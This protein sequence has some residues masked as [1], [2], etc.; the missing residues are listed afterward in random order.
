[1]RAIKKTEHS[2]QVAL[3]DW[4]KANESRHLQLGLMF[5][6]PNQGGKGK[7]AVIRGLRMVNEGLKKGVPDIFLGVP[8]NG[9]H[10]LFIELKVGKNKPSKN[11]LWWIHSLR[12]EGYAVEVCYGFEEARDLIIDFLE[13]EVQ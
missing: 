10:G 4:A 11:Q 2:E 5:A 7:S 9:K 3:F 1:M 6:I 8:R 12:T 13:I